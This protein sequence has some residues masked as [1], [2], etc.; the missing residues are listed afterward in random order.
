M[1]NKTSGGETG[2]ERQADE[3]GYYG[4][5]EGEVLS[6][7]PAEPEATGFHRRTFLKG[8]AA[9]AAGSAVLAGRKQ[10]DAAPLPTGDGTPAPPE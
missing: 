6:E 9:A 10:V 8:V 1:S 3:S 5:R 2:G 4:S 7:A